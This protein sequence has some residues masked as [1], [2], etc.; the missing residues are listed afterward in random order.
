MIVL[1]RVECNTCGQW[2]PLP[3]RRGRCA[4]CTGPLVGQLR[5]CCGDCD[6]SPCECPP[7]PDDADVAWMGH[8]EGGEPLDAPLTLAV[9]S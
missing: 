4:R 1:E 2:A 3:Y 7:H 5:V 6:R 8:H 9:A